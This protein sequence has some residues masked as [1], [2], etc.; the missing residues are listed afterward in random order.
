VRLFLDANVIMSAAITPEGR[1]AM[2]YDLARRANCTLTT[3]QHALTE[4]RRNVELKAYT[5]VG[6]FDQLQAQVIVVPPPAQQRIEFA[7]KL[8][9]AKDAPILAAAVAARADLLVTGDK[10]HFGPFY[11]ETFESTT[12]VSPEMTL[13]KLLGKRGQ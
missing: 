13:A 4:A 2:I 12:V 11:G 6:R 7:A 8:L 1:S 5:S 9:P 10:R 3:S